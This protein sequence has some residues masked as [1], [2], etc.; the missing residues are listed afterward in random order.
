MVKSRAQ[1]LRIA[2]GALAGL[3]I[4]GCAIRTPPPTTVT[5]PV[6][7]TVRSDLL[8][9]SAGD[10]LEV[11]IRRGAGEET[12]TGT[13]RDNGTLSV[14]FIDADVKGLSLMEAEK[15]LTE[16]LS[17]YI[18]DPRVQVLFKQKVITDR[19]FVFG[20]V[21][22]PGV[23]PLE[24]GMTVVD[25]VGKANGYTNYAYLPSVRVLRGGGN[26]PEVL[27]VDLDQLIYH[28]QLGQNLLLRNQ[29]IVFIP[30][31][32]IGDWNAFMKDLMPTLEV[33]EKALQPPILYQ[34]IRNN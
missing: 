23:I 19:I 15:K 27:A 22:K 16:M 29:D 5:E 7:S 24:P 20:E 34:T 12:Y 13:V 10:V 11:V 1:I 8:T 33:I 26:R 4:A 6:A 31:S 30:R 2:A 17:P 32:Q 28:G 18:K 21:N 25:A 9:I 3:I 14:S